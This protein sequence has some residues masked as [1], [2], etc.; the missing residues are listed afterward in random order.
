MF[1][2]DYFFAMFENEELNEALTGI[3][4]VTDFKHDVIKAMVDWIYYEKLPPSEITLDCLQAADKYDLPAFKFECQVLCLAMVC[5]ENVIEMLK[6]ADAYNAMELKA[7]II[8]IIRDNHKLLF[9]SAK[10]VENQLSAKLIAD[11]LVVNWD[12]GCDSD[13]SSDDDK[14]E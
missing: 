12:L 2:S 8:D 1:A 3:I 4:D 10:D 11:I 7:V 14:N 6:A 9:K 5:K 13:I